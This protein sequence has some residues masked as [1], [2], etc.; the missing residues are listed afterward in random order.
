MDYKL[1]VF[2]A[3]MSVFSKKNFVKKI[4]ISIIK[5]EKAQDSNSDNL[6]I[7]EYALKD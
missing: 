4:I 5:T 2:I 7:F 3:T 1:K 6:K